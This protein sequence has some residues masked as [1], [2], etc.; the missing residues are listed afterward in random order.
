MTLLAAHPASRY[1]V[2]GDAT[3]LDALPEAGFPAERCA[4]PSPV[5][6]LDGRAYSSKALRSITGRT[7]TGRCWASGIRA[8]YSIALSMLSQSTR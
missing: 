4:D 3:V 8:A 1:G 7:S 2:E 5:S 6:E